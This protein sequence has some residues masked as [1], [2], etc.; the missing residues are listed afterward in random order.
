MNTIAQLLA[1]SAL[2]AGAGA[3]A[4]ESIPVRV[5]VG[6]ALVNGESLEPYENSWRMEVTRGGETNHDAGLWKDRF[7][8]IDID[9]K[10]YG[11]RFQDATFK[12]KAGNVAATSRTVNVFDRRTMA[13]VTRYY[14]R[15]AVGKDDARVHIAF[16]AKAMTVT[17]GTDGRESPK[18]FSVA[19][20]FDFDGGLFALLWSAFPLKPGFAASLPSYSEDDH[21]EKVS[22]YTFRVVGTERIEAGREGSRDCWVVTGD[23]GSGPLKYWL[24]ADP[25]YIVQ[26]QYEQPGT[27][28]TWLLKMT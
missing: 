11:V 6:S 16:R 21:P 18:K 27:G 13:P 20:A 28:A 23:S 14:E 17:T 12:N 15:H 4:E 9:G 7:E 19:P 1:V 10:S 2:L 3:P 5:S 22:W 25:P 24:S 26:L 8:V